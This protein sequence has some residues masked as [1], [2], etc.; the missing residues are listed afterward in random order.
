[1]AQIRPLLL[2]DGYEDKKK[3]SFKTKGYESQYIMN[4]IY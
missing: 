2:S 1:M 3:S 4:G